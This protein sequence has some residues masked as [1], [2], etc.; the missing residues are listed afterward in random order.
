[1]TRKSQTYLFSLDE[2]RTFS[3]EIRKRFS[4]MRK[5][6]I[7]SFTSA[8]ELIK[9]VEREKEH[10]CCKVAVLS[11][12]ET[13][14]QLAAL[15]DITKE[16]KKCDFSTGIIVV[17]PADKEDE[18]NKALKFNIYA[19][20]PRNNN[21]IL[22]LHNLVKKMISEYNLEIYRRKKNLSFYILL[23][24]LSLSAIIFLVIYLRFPEYF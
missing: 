4:D 10:H 18:I 1:M 22:R 14:G 16:I 9:G 15:D 7:I 19:C 11:I 8:Q 21:T 13:T 17:Y 23:L 20:V 12:Y 5:Y 6:K 2:H 3:E 24:F